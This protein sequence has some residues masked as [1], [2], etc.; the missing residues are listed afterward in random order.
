MKKGF[1]AFYIKNFVYANLCFR[2][3]E[4]GPSNGNWLSQNLKPAR[5]HTQALIHRAL[6]STGGVAPT[7]RGAHSVPGTLSIQM[8]KLVNP[9]KNPIRGQ[10]VWKRHSWCS[11]HIPPVFPS[12]QS[13]RFFL[14]LE[15][16]VAQGEGRWRVI[17]E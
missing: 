14:A 6:L 4:A 1:L 16:H 9:L 13:G 8:W 12:A 2:S 5:L 10:G 7:L 11:A 15:A 3:C 17:K